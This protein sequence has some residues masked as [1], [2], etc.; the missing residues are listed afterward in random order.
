MDATIYAT[1]ENPEFTPLFK[2]VMWRTPNG[3][4][5]W[6]Q[7]FAPSRAALLWDGATADAYAIGIQNIHGAEAAFAY[8]S[9]RVTGRKDRLVPG[10]GYCGVLGR[11][12]RITFDIG[13]SDE[14]TLDC[15]V[16]HDKG[17]SDDV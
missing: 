3:V 16:V 11:K 13:T 14:A 6:T 1:A 17:T 10:T 15:W 7:V 4:Q 2:R 5:H 9:L 8:V 12:S